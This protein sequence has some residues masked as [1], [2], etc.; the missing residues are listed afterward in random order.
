MGACS[1][2]GEPKPIISPFVAMIFAST[3]AIGAVSRGEAD[4]I[5]AR[6]LE[7][8]AFSRP[9]QFRIAHPRG[10]KPRNESLNFVQFHRD[11]PLWSAH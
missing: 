5:A 1:R 10:F 9:I 4:L 7:P 3:P 8:L 11:Y 6:N 2:T